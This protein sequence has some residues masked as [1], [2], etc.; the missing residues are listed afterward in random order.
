MDYTE[1]PYILGRQMERWR[2]ATEEAIIGACLIDRKAFPRVMDILLPQTF[3][4]STLAEN[5]N[6]G[7]LS[8]SQVWQAMRE[9]YKSHPIDL[10]TITKRL[11]INHPEHESI[12][13]ALSNITER[14]ASSEN[15][16]THAL[17][18][19]ETSIRERALRLIEFSI[20]SDD[21]TKNADLT[22]LAK[23][24]RDQ[25]N[26]ILSSI[27]V[28]ISFLTEYGYTDESEELRN[29]LEMTE[30]RMLLIKKE[31]FR[32]HITEQFN[33]LKTKSE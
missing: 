14:I 11:I 12:A 27:E 17:L 20:D 3:L 6:R 4:H 23:Q 21:E 10:L 18:L 28:G 9:T 31:T 13:L 24:F 8:H 2:F 16:E 22:G 1:Q 7:R 32:K 30:V 29:L 5:K 19:I 25:R 33:L 15:I 26:D